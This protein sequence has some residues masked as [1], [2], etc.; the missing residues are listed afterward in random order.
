MK[1][2]LFCGGLG[3]RLRELTGDLPKPIIRIGDR[4]ILWHVMRYYAHFGHCDF[5]LCLG[6]KAEAIRQYFLDE[7]EWM[8]GSPA[9]SEGGRQVDL[10]TRDA[11]T[12]RIT[13]VD[14]GV[15][16]SVGM[17]LRAVRPYL[18]GEDLFFANYADGLTDLDLPRM[19]APFRASGLTACCL[20]T[21]PPQSFHIVQLDGDNLV[22][23]MTEARRSTV[24][25]NG[26]YFIFRR[27]IFEYVGE[28]EDLVAEPFRRLIR[29]RQLLGYPYDRFWCMDTFKDHCELTALH[30]S[31]RAPWE[32]W[33]RDHGSPASDPAVAP[34]IL[35]EPARRREP[36]RLRR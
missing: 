33:R 30:E 7:Q 9:L 35:A 32:V 11:G 15:D 21:S 6:Y 13:L 18:E 27:E 19:I 24:A 25:I 26:G 16:A 10:A 1:V 5:V 20:C 3:A 36:A 2:V 28:G 4:P 22:R 17:R 8:C 34:G 29:A 23:D 12:W 14:T 31:G